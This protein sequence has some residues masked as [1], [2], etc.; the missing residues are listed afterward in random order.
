M[1]WIKI[2]E[3]YDLFNPYDRILSDDYYDIGVVKEIIDQYFDDVWLQ[4]YVEFKYDRS[5]L[6]T[7]FSGSGPKRRRRTN[8]VKREETFMLDLEEH[9]DANTYQWNNG[10]RDVELWITFCIKGEVTQEQVDDI[11][12]RVSDTTTMPVHQLEWTLWQKDRHD[13]QIIL[14]NGGEGQ[15]RLIDC[16]FNRRISESLT[17]WQRQDIWNGISDIFQPV[18]E[19]E[20]GVSVKQ[21]IGSD[22]IYRVSIGKM[23]DIGIFDTVRSYHQLDEDLIDLVEQ[24]A[25]R[26]R[27]LGY[28]YKIYLMYSPYPKSS[29]G[30]LRKLRLKDK[31][32]YDAMAMFR[33]SDTVEVIDSWRDQVG[34]DWTFLWQVDIS[35]FI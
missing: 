7:T 35:V 32:G 8:V 26:L 21:Q 19:E 10:I 20:V 1:K 2:F 25:T 14:D 4:L 18:R 24:C 30:R 34:D 12:Q 3:E 9:T 31:T 33:K 16:L 27:G 5:S 11:K 6:H 15:K 17:T 29:L 22:N 13:I 23:L 28:E